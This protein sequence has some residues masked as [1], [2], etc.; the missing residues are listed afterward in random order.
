MRQTRPHSPGSI[1]PSPR[2]RFLLWQASPSSRADANAPT[3]FRMMVF[4][5]RASIGGAFAT[6]A[7][8]LSGQY[9]SLAKGAFL[10]LASVSFVPSGRKRAYYISD[11]GLYRPR[12]HRRSV[13]DKR[14]H[15]LRAKAFPR[16]GR[17][18]CS[19]KRLL[20]RRADANAPTISH[21]QPSLSSLETVWSR[22]PEVAPTGCWRRTARRLCRGVP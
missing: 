4:T 2:A 22:R 15:T 12:Q 16:K 6:N 13:C 1:I 5:G 3:T 11:D 19:G 7:T 17:A 21:L 20:R 9:H 8:T 14:D 18:S 10:A